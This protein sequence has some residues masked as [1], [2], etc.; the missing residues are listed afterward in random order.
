MA[1]RDIAFDAEGVTL[2]GWLYLPDKIPRPRSRPRGGDGTRL[3]R[4]EGDVPR[5]LRRGVRR[6]RPRGDRVR[7]SQLRRLR[8]GASRRD[9]PLGAGPRLPARHQLPPARTLPE[10]DPD[11]LG[12]LG[13]ELQRRARP[14]GRVPL[15]HGS[16]LRGQP[17]AGDQRPRQ[18]P[19]A[20]PG[21]FHRR[22]PRD[23]RRRP[24]RPLPGQAAG[25]GARGRQG[26]AG[27][28]GAADAGLVGVVHPDRGDP[29]AGLAERGDAAQRGDV[30]RVRAG[31]LPA[32]HQP[33]AAAA[34]GRRGRP[35]G[36][37]PS[38]PSRP[39]TRRT[40]PRSSSSCQAVTSTLTRWAWRP[41]AARRATGSCATWAAASSGPGWSSAGPGGWPS[42]GPAARS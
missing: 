19:R 4:G 14:G 23:V 39:S 37:R 9:R 24:P 3:H 34:A 35:P 41:R 28:V 18:P 20:G 8:R 36:A 30:H 5:H 40:S 33:H 17:G 27:S 31:Q 1:R 25:H 7:P 42:T 12:D 21:R 26:P 32:V 38:S 13:H 16:A 11:R 6:R 2:R 22:V 15:D 29:G 10:I